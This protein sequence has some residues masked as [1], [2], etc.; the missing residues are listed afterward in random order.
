MERAFC[1]CLQEVLL[2]TAFSNFESSA[3]FPDVSAE[4]PSP[5][6]CSFGTPQTTSLTGEKWPFIPIFNK[7]LV[8]GR[9]FLFPP[10][11]LEL[12]M[13]EEKSH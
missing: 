7:S 4:E 9:L 11:R 10:T 12:D 13:S 2:L 6:T 8:P 5:H 3:L 1:N